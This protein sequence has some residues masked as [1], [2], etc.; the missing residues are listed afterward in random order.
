MADTGKFADL[1]GKTKGPGGPT[2]VGT[3]VKGDTVSD[4]LAHALGNVAPGADALNRADPI[5][6]VF[7]G[8]FANAITDFMTDVQEGSVAVGLG[9]QGAYEQLLRDGAMKSKDT[10]LGL[11]I[12]GTSGPCD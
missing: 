7:Y 11:E 10:C 2:F 4:E 1:S 6:G 9:M 3:R 8:M 12:P 5:L